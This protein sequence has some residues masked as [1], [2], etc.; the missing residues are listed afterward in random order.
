MSRDPAP[1]GRLKG[2]ARRFQL[3]VR[4]QRQGA[5]IALVALVLFRAARYGHDFYQ[6][7]NLRDLLGDNAKFGFIA[8]GMTFVIMSGG[9]DLSVGSVV[10]LGGVLA[11]QQSGHRLLAGLSVGGA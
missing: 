5:L 9:I 2:A 6:G 1:S 8:L 4:I 7:S 10:A 3:G 11:T